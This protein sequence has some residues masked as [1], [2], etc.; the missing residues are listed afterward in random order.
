MA[1]VI[2]L[3]TSAA[4]APVPLHRPGHGVRPTSDARPGRPSL[5]VIEGGRSEAAI[6]QRRTYMRRRAA[7]AVLGLAAVALLAAGLS[8]AV[9]QLGAGAL[10]TGPAVVHRVQPGDTLWSLA[11]S[12][13]PAA[14][15][16]DVID[17]I[18]ELNS[19]R[20]AEAVAFSPDE[21]L[22]VGQELRIPAT[23]G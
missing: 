15:P 17:V 16:R 8:A 18:V 12:S 4:V 9:G 21:P 10:H 19:G 1:A 5:A 6:A 7:V 14:D 2:D 3:R 13:D 23:A 22:R 20:G 11:V